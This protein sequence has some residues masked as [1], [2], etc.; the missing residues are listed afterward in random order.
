MD[1]AIQSHPGD[2]PAGFEV[3]AHRWLPILLAV[4][5]LAQFA[6]LLNEFNLMTVFLGVL[7]AFAAVVQATWRALVSPHGITFTN[8]VGVDWDRAWSD[9]RPDVVVKRPGRIG[10]L[11]SAR[12]RTGRR[13]GV[14]NG[15]V[16]TLTGAPIAPETAQQLMQA[17]ADAGTSSEPT[18]P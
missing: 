7:L 2:I 9:L 12:L 18:L 15:R 16:T 1:D 10:S 5:S 6:T 3:R 14:T 8:K 17:W 11:V 4:T 13:I